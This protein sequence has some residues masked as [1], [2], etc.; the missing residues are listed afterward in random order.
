MY[1]VNIYYCYYILITPPLY[2]C[3]HSP[4]IF[5]N[6]CH[7]SSIHSCLLSPFSCSISPSSCSAFPTAGPFF[8]FLTISLSSCTLSLYTVPSP[9]FQI[10]PAPFLPLPAPISQLLVLFSQFIFPSSFHFPCLSVPSGPL[11]F[12][13]Q[14]LLLFVQLMSF[15]LCCSYLLFSVLISFAHFLFA[16]LHFLSSYS[17]IPLSFHPVPVCVLL[18]LSLYLML[19]C[20]F[21]Y[22]DEIDCLQSAFSLKIGLVL[23]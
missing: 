21:V 16:L 12:T 13:F 2:H 18:V 11:L 1:T 15:L 9:L 17:P 7:L 8:Q 5:P 4:P 19:P 23:S 22:W 20:F 6:F 10:W 14:F 3:C